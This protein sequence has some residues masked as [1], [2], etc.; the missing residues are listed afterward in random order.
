LLIVLILANFS[1]GGCKLA[2]AKGEERDRSTTGISTDLTINT[3]V[4]EELVETLELPFG[5]I[6]E[7]QSIGGSETAFLALA[8]RLHEADAE[9]LLSS[10]C[11]SA[12]AEFFLAYPGRLT[13]TENAFVAFH[14]NSVLLDHLSRAALP[15]DHANCFSESASRLQRYRNIRLPDNQILE[16]QL[17]SIGRYKITVSDAGD[18]SVAVQYEHAWWVPTSSDLSNLFKIDVPASICNDDD[19]C[20]MGMLN[21]LGASGDPVLLGERTVVVPE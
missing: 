15:A 9:V 8:Q 13:V 1:L 18:C 4:T 6:V 7:V 21:L 5:G 16:S 14:H 11:V 19:S 17:K 3:K 12:C 2:T 10:I 20:A